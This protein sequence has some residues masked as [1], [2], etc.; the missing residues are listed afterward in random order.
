MNR[1]IIYCALI[2]L[3]PYLL[4]GRDIAPGFDFLK[5]GIGARPCGMGEAFTAV[6]DD[7]SA[8]YWNPAGIGDI[9]GLRFLVMHTEWFLGTRFEHFSGILPLHFGSISLSVTYLTS[10]EIEGRNEYGE[11]TTPYRNYDI[12]GEIGYGKKIGKCFLF[13]LGVK[14]I[15]EKIENY[16][17]SGFC[18]DAGCLLKTALGL[19]LGVSMQNLGTP[20]R[21]IE[22]DTKL[23][24]ALRVGISYNGKVSIGRVLPAFDLVLDNSVKGNFG[25]EFVMLDILALRGGYRLGLK[26]NCF[27]LGA[28]IDHNLGKIGLQVDYAYTGFSDL[29]S[30]HRLSLCFGL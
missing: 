3:T 19:N 27:T 7:G 30:G 10:G 12:A 25:L 6:A 23:P 22:R 14:I 26:Q 20:I 2:F 13:G 8:L 24:M 18:L 9:N 11:L 5:L 1:K 17:G 16:T 29:G 28:G 4:F 15:Q 21:F